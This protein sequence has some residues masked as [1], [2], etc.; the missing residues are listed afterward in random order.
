MWYVATNAAILGHSFRGNNFS[1]GTAV[2]VSDNRHVVESYPGIPS[3]LMEVDVREINLVKRSFHAEGLDLLNI[4]DAST[5]NGCSFSDNCSC[6]SAEN[7]TWLQ[8]AL[9][10]YLFHLFTISRGT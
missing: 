5:L 6:K 7:R 8:M 4:I 9:L 10:W 3:R 1:R 2:V